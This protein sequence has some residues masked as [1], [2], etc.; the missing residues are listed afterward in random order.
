MAQELE[1]KV[2]V[3]RKEF[4]RCAQLLRRH[5]GVDGKSYVQVNYYFDTPTFALAAAH[6][7]LRVRRK[8]DSLY[9]QFKNKRTR[10]GDLMLCDEVEKKISSL[11]RSV[12]PSEFF[13]GAP[14]GV[15]F[16]LGD[17]VTSRTDYVLPGVVVSFDENFYL[18]KTDF[19]IEIEGERDAID[20]VTTV[21]RPE[22]AKKPRGKFSRFLKAYLRYQ[23]PEERSKS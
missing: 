3:T 6:C 7:M 14:K 18:G 13:P 19:E 16:L 15:C 4:D 20:A 21:L 11:P 23:Q 9:L 8:R 22:A 1:R 12:D 10:D 5:Y 17:L 2:R